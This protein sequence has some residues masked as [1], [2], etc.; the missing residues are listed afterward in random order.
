MSKEGELALVGGKIYPKINKTKIAVAKKIGQGYEIIL[1]K[2]GWGDELR[3]LTESAP[4]KL[5][6]SDLWRDQP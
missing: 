3:K 1:S 6:Y 5:I 4:P 2:I